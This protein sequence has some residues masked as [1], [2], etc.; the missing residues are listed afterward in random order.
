MLLARIKLRWNIYNLNVSSEITED[1]SRNSLQ[2]QGMN[3]TCPLSFM[4]LLKL[5][6]ENE[7]LHLTI[8]LTEMTLNLHRYLAIE[9][10]SRFEGFGCQEWKNGLSLNFFS[11]A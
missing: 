10:V 5:Q 8:V 6:V 3:I 1:W 4:L 11:A 7:P 2:L 9:K